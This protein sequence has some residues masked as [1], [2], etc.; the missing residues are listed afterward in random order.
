MKKLL[1]FFL[2]LFLTSQTFAQEV[3]LANYFDIKTNQVAGTS[4]TGKVNLKSNK[5]VEKTPIPASYR[6]SIENNADIFEIATEFD[7]K[8]RIFGVLKVAT[9][10]NSG[11]AKDYNLNILLKD[12]ATLKATKSIVIHVAETTLWTQLKDYYTPITISE[13]RMYGR[14][15]FSDSQ[16]VSYLTQ[17]ENNNGK[18]SG[19]SFYTKHPS[20]F[21]SGVLEAEYQSVSELI[22]GLGYAYAKSTTYGIPS[23]NATNM[24]RL[25]RAI[26]KSVMAY[27]NNVPIYG[28]DLLIGGKPIGTELGD[29]ISKMSERG[30]VSHNFLT[31]QWRAT[32][33]LSAPLV[34]IWPELLKDIEFNDAEA[35]Q[36]YSSVIRFYQ[37]FFSEVPSMRVMNDDAGVWGNIS[38]LNYSEGAWSDG[39][40]SHRMRTLM[41]LP[42]L[43]ADY[44]R[45]I[46]YV[47]YWYDDYYNNTPLKGKTFAHNW[48][49]NGVLAD[50][51]HWCGRLS[52][53]TQAFDQSGFHPDG[54]VTHHKGYNAS[55]VAM[56]AYGFE[57]LITNN[58]ASKYF[59]NTP[60]EMDD[61]GLQFVSD[62]INYSYRRLIYKNS[63]DFLVTGRSFFADLSAFGS[64]D[65]KNTIDDLMI[66][67]KSS[68][69]I[70]NQTELL[71][72]RANLVNGTHTHTETTSFWDA[73]YLMHRK[74][75]GNENYYFSVK[76]KSVRTAGSEDF[77]KIRKSWH[78]GSGVFLLRVTGNEYN[79]K[80]LQNFDWHVLPG[81]TEEWRT[82]A[83]PTGAASDSKP[84]GNIFS[85]ILSD[86]TY[87]IS[88][89]HHKPIDTYTGAEA[90][91]SYFLIGK[92][93]TA[94]G[95]DV[96]RK[97]SSSGKEIVTTI[98]QSE[99]LETITYNING[100]SKTVTKGSSV[101]LVEPLTGP[102]WIHH[103]DKGYLVFPKT[104][105]NLLIKTGSNIN[106]T[107]TDLGLTQSTNYILALDHGVNPTTQKNGYKYVMVANVTLQEMPDVLASY[108]ANTQIYSADGN[109]HAV[110]DGVE[111][112]KQVTFFQA[113]RVNFDDGK[114]IEVDKPALVMTKEFESDLRLTVLNPLH[115][116]ST[117]E[118]TVKIP[119]VLKAGTYNY[120]LPG[121]SRIA[122]ESARVTTNGTTE[123]T[124]VVSLPSTGDGILYNYQE[125]V[126]AGAPIVIT[127]QKGIPLSIDLPISVKNTKVKIY[128]IPVKDNSVVEA[129]DGSSI[130]KVEIY[131]MLG[132][133]LTSQSYTGKLS[134]VKLPLEKYLIDKQ[135]NLVVK[136]TTSKEITFIKLM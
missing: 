27:M 44:N 39:N 40:L 4:V 16:L 24:A 20:T 29:G 136:V 33:A 78:A 103:N 134:K 23:G 115:S 102:T 13:S 81:V 19:F 93:G 112:L 70:A 53:P 48:S 66:A 10:K 123:S 80:V 105:Q 57:W 77:D 61:K 50:V 67:K 65:I 127:L 97:A 87:G 120:S 131:N 129:T 113:N 107:A 17:L 94:V 114:W 21:A 6:F 96:K 15:K 99:Q 34:Y 79:Q 22:G 7:D 89:Y 11:G 68:T 95:T 122:G 62:R 60:L 75:E 2:G 74:E 64:K 135:E 104:G 41:T 84:G 18:F 82:D 73:D 85:G 1:P 83:M 128:P 92:Y 8:G 126:Y 132:Q 12:G 69:V 88:G 63:L 117:S 118:I 108:I 3:L 30:F 116:L 110:T 124:I 54:T 25:K 90:L 35:K 14:T 47:P 133:L 111:Q 101:N 28:N 42:I 71:S 49:P 121:V 5:D 125:Q 31:H 76:N 37:L 119:Q 86:G 55:D 9:G 52:T 46:T 59:K 26:Y 91:K 130:R 51:K 56:V 106:I 98:D 58:D 32:D 38:N 36:V 72:L 43:W 109:Y 45:P 100:T